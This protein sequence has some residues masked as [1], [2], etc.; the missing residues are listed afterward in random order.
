MRSGATAPSSKRAVQPLPKLGS[1]EP[2]WPRLLFI[3]AKKPDR[4]RLT[5]VQCSITYAVSLRRR[6]G[7]LY[8]A[9]LKAKIC[10]ETKIFASQTR[11]KVISS[12]NT[13]MNLSFHLSCDVEN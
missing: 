12:T 3:I 5:R 11:V 13:V 10:L 6:P 8:A 9:R 7:M 2:I 1:G 4:E